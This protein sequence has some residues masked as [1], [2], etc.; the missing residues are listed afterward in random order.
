MVALLAATANAQDR[1]PWSL[2]YAASHGQTNVI[3][4][5]LSMGVDANTRGRDGKRALDIACLKGDAEV[6]ELL[7]AHGAEVNAKDAEDGSAPLHI[8]ASFGRT[9]AVKALVSRGGDIKLKNAKGLTAFDLAVR[10]GY[11][12]LAALVRPPSE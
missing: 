12:E 3:A 5:L 7:L 2:Q 8:G 1:T 11:K 4:M 6:V 9:D 10:N